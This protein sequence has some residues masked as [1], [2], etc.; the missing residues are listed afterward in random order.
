[1]STISS[2][3]AG[4]PLQS[5]RITAS[6]GGANAIS[7]KADKNPALNV[8]LNSNRDVDAMTN[9]LELSG[10]RF[11]DL[12]ALFEKGFSLPSPVMPA[13]LQEA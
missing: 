6:E 9:D 13:V 4:N 12:D 8:S 5:T 11:A 2:I 3:S 10:P 1:M 7:P